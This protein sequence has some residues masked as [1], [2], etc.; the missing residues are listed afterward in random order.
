MSV[1]TLVPKR[2]WSQ[3]NFI[4]SNGSKDIAGITLSG[5]R[6]WREKGVLTVEGVD[7]HAYRQ[8]YGDGAMSGD[9]VVERDGVELARAAKPSG[10][11]NAFVLEYER[12]RYPLRRKIWTRRLV[13]LDGDQVLGTIAPQGLWSR[14]LT[15]TLPDNWPLPVKVFVAWLALILRTRDGE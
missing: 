8:V 10:F 5:W 15:V 9:F 12:K 6:G 1:L 2:W 7:H 11:R 13:L 4:I 3:R 14:R